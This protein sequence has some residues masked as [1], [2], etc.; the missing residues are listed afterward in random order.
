VASWCGSTRAQ[1]GARARGDVTEYRD[2]PTDRPGT[3]APTAD[4]SCTS[5]GHGATTRAPSLSRSFRSCRE[6]RSS[7]SEGHRRPPVHSVHSIIIIIR[8]RVELPLVARQGARRRE[9]QRWHRGESPPCLPAVAFCQPNSLCSLLHR[10]YGSIPL[11]FAPGFWF[12]V[13]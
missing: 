1:A 2:D 7:S 12:I 3:L 6:I 10:T 8:G 5:P 13:R 4:G 11:Y 9:R